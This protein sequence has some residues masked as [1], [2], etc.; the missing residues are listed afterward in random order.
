M[1][2][3][4]DP[5]QSL[6]QI[7]D[8][9]DY[10]DNRDI[11][12]DEFLFLCQQEILTMLLESISEEKRQELEQELGDKP[13]LALMQT[14]LEKYFTEEQRIEA[15]EK[16]T[17]EVYKDFFKSIVPTLAQ[18]QKEKLQQYLSSLKK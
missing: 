7:L 17:T 1:N 11:F 13:T 3:V 14:L 15:T 18:K 2:N 5:K 12:A 8:I 4:L 6:L 16:A 9:I 10:Q